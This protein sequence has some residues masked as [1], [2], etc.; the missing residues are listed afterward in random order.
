VDVIGE[1]TVRGIGWMFVGKGPLLSVTNVNIMRL[2]WGSVIESCAFTAALLRCE[3]ASM[4]GT[5]ID[6]K[7]TSR[8]QRTAF[9]SFTSNFSASTFSYASFMTP[10]HLQELLQSSSCVA[11]CLHLCPLPPLPPPPP[12]PR[13]YISICPRRLQIRACTSNSCQT[14]A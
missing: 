2:R 13:P 12:P 4:I 3:R 10:C 11:S 7:H 6:C 8:W 5:E 9:G 14:L 1:V